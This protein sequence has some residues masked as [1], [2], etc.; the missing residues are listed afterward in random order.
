MPRTRMLARLLTAG[1]LLTGCADMEPLYRSEA[2]VP[3]ET[4]V[5][6]AES[7]GAA[8][9]AALVLLAVL[10]VHPSDHAPTPETLA[11]A[12]EA[13]GTRT[14]AGTLSPTHLAAATEAATACALD[15]L[16]DAVVRMNACDLLA[17]TGAD[18]AL[19]RV[20]EEAAD[21][22]VADHAAGLMERTPAR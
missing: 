22:L 5:A 12:L 11:T 16:Q 7:D 10:G 21:P 13:L 1:L 17:A 20:A 8:D 18:G 3:A 2:E 15:D 9:A 14:E 4:L 6:A 19:G